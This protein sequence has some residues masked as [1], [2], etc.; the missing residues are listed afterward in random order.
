[1]CATSVIFVSLEAWH[2]GGPVRLDLLRK[3]VFCKCNIT[4]VTVSLIIEHQRRLSN[5]TKRQWLSKGGV[6]AH[7]FGDEET[8]SR[9][10]GLRIV[11]ICLSVY[12]FQCLIFPIRSGLDDSVIVKRFLRSF[13]RR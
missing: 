1:V 11:H 13:R 6:L 7:Y 9:A 12:E 8:A 2:A 4:D 10:W 3:W 5:K